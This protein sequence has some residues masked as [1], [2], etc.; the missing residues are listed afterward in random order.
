MTYKL[1]HLEEIFKGICLFGGCRFAPFSAY[2][3]ENRNMMKKLTRNCRR[4]RRFP[5]RSP[6]L[7]L[8]KKRL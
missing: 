2:A 1:S 3:A 6:Q 5:E 4:L 8:L 7:P